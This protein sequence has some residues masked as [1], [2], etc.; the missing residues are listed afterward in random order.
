MILDFIIRLPPFKFKN[1]VYDFIF[2]IIDYYIKIIYY[3]LIIKEITAFKL[4]ELF[5]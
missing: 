3:I 1:K 2:I 5:I 4:V